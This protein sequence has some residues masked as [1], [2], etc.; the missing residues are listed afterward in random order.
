MT[1]V[2]GSKVICIV[3]TIVIITLS[4]LG[5]LKISEK[6]VQLAKS[7]KEWEI[8]S[9]KLENENNRVVKELKL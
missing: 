2:H 3:M 7:V 1:F 9:L 6:K 4:T 5:L 8:S